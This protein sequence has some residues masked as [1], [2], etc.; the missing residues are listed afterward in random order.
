MVNKLIEI[1]HF[2]IF[3]VFQKGAGL[4][5]NKVFSLQSSDIIDLNKSIRGECEMIRQ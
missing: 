4:D 1:L 3:E 5:L 2:T